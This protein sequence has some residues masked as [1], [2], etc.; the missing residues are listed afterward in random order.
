MIKETYSAFWVVQKIGTPIQFVTYS[1]G[2][3]EDIMSARKYMS[4][5][6]AQEWCDFVENEHNPCRIRKVVITTKIELE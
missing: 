2:L 6:E 5:K 4:E 1:T 3:T